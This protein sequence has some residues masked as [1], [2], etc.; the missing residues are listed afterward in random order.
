MK[1]GSRYSV[2]A[3]WPGALYEHTTKVTTL[4]SVN[5]A[6][7]LAVALTTLS[8]AAWDATVWTDAHPAIPPAIATLVDSLREGGGDGVP[9]IELSG[10]G[11]RHADTWSFKQL[12]DHLAGEF[13]VFPP[14][15]RTQCLTVA[16]EIAADAAARDALMASPSGVFADDSRAHQACLVTRIEENGSRGPLPEGAA[17]WMRRLYPENMPLHER[18]GARSQL[19]RMEQLVAACLASGGRAQASTDPLSAYC[20]VAVEPGHINH[21]DTPH[22]ASPLGPKA[23]GF[24]TPNPLGPL[25]IERDGKLIG[26][27]DPADDEGFAAVMGEWTRAVPYLA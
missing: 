3:T 9:A 13:D 2:L 10:V 25:Y 17:G 4:D 16:D 20:V 1:V 15:T 23:S 7:D 6:N 24:D 18:W 21:G 5:S 22:S 11:Y 27:L 12:R 8:E 14:L 26:E 19:L